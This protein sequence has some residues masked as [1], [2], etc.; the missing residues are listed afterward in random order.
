MST[1]PTSNDN[2]D[3]SEEVRS[4]FD[5]YFTGQLTFPSNQVDAVIG[6]FMKRG[7]SD[8]SARSTSIVLLNQAKV[9]NVNVF[10]LLDTLK[11]LTDVQLSGVVTEILNASREATSILGYK[12][13]ATEETLESRNIRP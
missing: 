3:S 5:K 1:L 13:L 4:F 10:Q 6:F 12:I 9:D 2:K 11:G 7:F 8:L